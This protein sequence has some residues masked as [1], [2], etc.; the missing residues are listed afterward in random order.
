MKKI[1]LLLL[2]F[3]A[4]QVALAQA[5]SLTGT[6][7][8]S[9]CT[10]GG[11]G[12]GYALFTYANNNGAVSYTVAPASGC[13]VWSTDSLKI[14][15]AGTYTVTATAAGNMATSS[16]VVIVPNATSSAYIAAGTTSLCSNGI[17]NTSTTLSAVYSAYNAIAANYCSAQSTTADLEDIT[18]VSIGAFTN[19]SSC[20]STG[21]VGSL[22]GRYSNYTSQVI[23]ANLGATL[24]VSLTIDTCSNTGTATNNSSIF[25]DLNIDGDFA[26][27]GERVYS[28]AAASIGAHTETGTIVVPTTATPGLSRLRVITAQ[29]NSS[30]PCGTY[31]GGEVEDYSIL[32]GSAVPSYSWTNGTS[33]VSTTNTYV[34]PGSNAS[35]TLTVT[36]G[37]GCSYTSSITITT[38]TAPIVSILKQNASCS[39]ASLEAIVSGGAANVLWTPSNATATAITNLTSG[40]YTCT[41]TNSAGCA[42]TSTAAVTPFPAIQSNATLQHIK[43]SG[44]NDG[45]I[46]ISANGGANLFFY[47]WAPLPA[48]G[49]DSVAKNLTAGSYSVTVTDGLGCTQTF[50]YTLTQSNNPMN[51]GVFASNISAAGANDG[52][53]FAIVFGGTPPYTYSWSPTVSV[54][55]SITNLSPTI[56]T[57]TVSDSKGCVGTATANIFEPGAMGL[58]DAQAPQLTYWPNPAERK[59]YL[60]NAA[61]ISKAEIISSNGSLIAVHVFNASQQDQEIPV[62]QLSAGLYFLRINGSGRLYKFIKN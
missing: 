3:C 47:S 6:A 32:I 34:A 36:D 11:C 17:A 24:A 1:F 18:N 31:N 58:Q 57:V 16:T 61:T 37:S 25:V 55:D 44:T 29:S 12:N 22:L 56:Y 53:I 33:T 26:D 60:S 30:A 13:H 14:L 40:T 20:G 43:C 49:T 48:T 41:A 52:K 27:P 7:Y 51:V 28:S 4:T 45:Q 8:P 23:T 21:G 15:N 54:A 59:L 62:D 38:S 5:F 42:A 10:S 2:S 46:T 19:A 50:T 39:Y 35:Y 9:T